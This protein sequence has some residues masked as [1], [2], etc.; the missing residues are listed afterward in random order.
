[1]NAFV[2]ETRHGPLPVTLKRMKRARRISVRL[3]PKERGVIV[4][5]PARASL[6]AARDFAESARGWVEAQMDKTPQAASFAADA[7]FPLR[8]APCRIVHCPERRDVRYEDGV[9]LVGGG[10]EFLA[11]R[12]R[13]WLKARA[14]TTLTA[15]TA[16]HA[17]R[18]GARITRITLRDTR[19]RWGSAS[20]TGALSFSWRLILAPEAVLEYVAAHEVA[21]LREMNHS[22][23]FWRLVEELCPQYESARRWLRR[24]GGEL[25]RIG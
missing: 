16:E 3:H 20:H 6:R 8:G 1:M 7:S 22:P 10:A 15:R 5:L 17:S 24:H 2:L 19:S 25:H 4:T 18:L 9:L 21:H 14:R 12:V 13:D 23:R 11:R